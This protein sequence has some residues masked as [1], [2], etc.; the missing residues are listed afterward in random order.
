MPRSQFGHWL[1]LAEIRV[2]NR[3]ALVL[4]NMGLIHTEWLALS[5]IYAAGSQSV[6]GL[7]EA[8]GM[9]RGGASK[10]VKRLVDACL[11]EKEFSEFDRRYRPLRLTKL[12]F[13][14]TQ[15][16]A[17]E[18]NENESNFFGE[19]PSEDRDVLSRT[20]FGVVHAPRSNPCRWVCEELPI[21]LF[22]RRQQC[23]NLVRRELPISATR[24]MPPELE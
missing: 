5:E 15:Q 6:V 13:D 9:T 16:L 10:L 18:A 21:P 2:S 11:V 20:L 7:A 19:L 1:K 12:G 24:Y 3:F 17:F 4:A 22:R 8:I 23:A 14:I